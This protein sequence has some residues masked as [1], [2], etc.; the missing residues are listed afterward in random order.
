M[1]LIQ[2]SGGRGRTARAVTQRNPVLKKKK[3]Q[4]IIYSNIVYGY[5]IWKY[6]KLS[7]HSPGWSMRTFQELVKFHFLISQ[8]WVSAPEWPFHVGH[9]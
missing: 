9:L 7:V 1:P 3:K 6:L 2:H 8:L 5:C 4:A